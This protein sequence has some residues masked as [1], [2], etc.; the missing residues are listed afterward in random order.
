MRVLLDTHDRLVLR[1]LTLG[2][3][4]LILAVACIP[5]LMAYGY[6]RAGVWAGFWVLA[7]ITLLLLIGC[8]GSFVRPLTIILDRS[9]DRVEVVERSLFGSRREV[10]VLKHIRGATTQARVIR[11]KPGDRIR[12]GTRLGRPPPEPRVHRAA[13]VDV[14]GNQIPLGSVFGSAEAAHVAAAAINGWIGSEL[15]AAGR[16]GR[17][18]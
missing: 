15:V 7:G 16:P 4:L 13:L 11:R 3:G 12:K 9:G 2:P 14:N 1:D 6:L 17:P 5:A 10:H 18:T 8:M